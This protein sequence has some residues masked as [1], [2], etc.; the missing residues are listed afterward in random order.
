M[1]P[2]KNLTAFSTEDYLSKDVVAAKGSGLSVWTG[3]DNSAADKLFLHLVLCQEK[4]QVK[5][6]LFY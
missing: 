4:V 1:H 6:E 3:M 2:A 5:R